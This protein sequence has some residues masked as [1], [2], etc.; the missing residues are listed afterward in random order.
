MI[1][2]GLT[3]QRNRDS[4]LDKNVYGKDFIEFP[5]LIQHQE[6]DMPDHI[7]SSTNI[8]KRS[9]RLSTNTNVRPQTTDVR[10]R[11]FA[12][13]NHSPIELSKKFL[14]LGYQPAGSINS[15]GQI[16]ES[17]EEIIAKLGIYVTKWI[18]YSTKYGLG[19]MLSDGTSGVAFNDHTKLVMPKSMT[20]VELNLPS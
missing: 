20:Y 18:D 7:F 13:I 19:Y 9:D 2:V 3:S 1:I 12:S 14:P 11:P 16:K 6:N 5:S 15:V 4:A 17:N 10:A 8:N